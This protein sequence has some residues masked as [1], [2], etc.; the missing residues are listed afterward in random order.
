M[1]A[2]MDLPCSDVWNRFS[3][4]TVIYTSLS[5]DTI[6][7]CIIYVV[8]SSGMFVTFVNFYLEM[9][10]MVSEPDVTLLRLPFYN[11]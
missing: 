10:L 8:P 6:G 11:I 9:P 3:K 2:L 5:A 1:C 4:P 7:Q